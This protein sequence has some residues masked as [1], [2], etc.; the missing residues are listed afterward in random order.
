MFGQLLAAIKGDNTLT[1][2]K[3]I[4]HMSNQELMTI[5]QEGKT[6]LHHAAEKDNGKVVALL[7]NKNPNLLN[8]EDYS[9]NTAMFLAKAY[10]SQKVL[11]VLNNFLASMAYLPPSP[12][13]LPALSTEL[14][15]DEASENAD[16]GGESSPF[17]GEMDMP[18][19]E[20]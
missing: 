9:H 13:D 4:I 19:N 6:A 3:M 10:E 5:D 15:A 17:P 16:L 1:A 12:N 11:A 18:Y 8:M 20:V 14:S 2:Q 7:L